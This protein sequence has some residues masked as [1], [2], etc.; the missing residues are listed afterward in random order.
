MKPFNNLENKTPL[1]TY[2]IVQLVGKKV[3]AHSYLEPPLEHNKDQMP[4]DK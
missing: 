2:W 4:F 1:D 3:Q